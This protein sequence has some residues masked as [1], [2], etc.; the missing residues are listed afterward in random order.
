MFLTEAELD[1]TEKYLKQGYVILPVANRDALDW[2]RNQFVG[3]ISEAIGTSAKCDPEDLLNQIHK[4]IPVAELNTFR[5][6]IIQ[7]FNKI[8][9]F[10]EM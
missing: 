7:G 5:L 9:Q 3:L 10:R 6:K 1:L 2:M 4:R 8:K